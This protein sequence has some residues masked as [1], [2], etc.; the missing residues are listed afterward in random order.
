MIQ[1]GIRFDGFKREYSSYNPIIT[2][3]TV[4]YNCE[5]HIEKTIKSVISQTYQN[6]E[7]IIIDGN[8]TDG[9]LDI[10]RKYEKYIDYW[11]SEKDSGVFDAMNKGIYLSTS[12]WVL[13]LNAGDYLASSDSISNCIKY[14]DSESLILY[15]NTILYRTNNGNKYLKELNCDH[16]AKQL[17][18]QSCLYNKYLHLMYGPYVVSPRVTISDYLFFNLI[19]EKYWK[20]T[21][22]I[23]SSYLVD[24]N[25]S[26]GVSHFM[27]HL[28]VDLIFSSK[29]SVILLIRSI[30]SIIKFFIKKLILKIFK[31]SFYI[32]K[33]EKFKLDK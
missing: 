14:I 18:H 13:F 27:Q 25:I 11:I 24:S 23:I 17:I 16:Q 2:I 4:V 5:S 9:T 15:S 31:V 1:G 19:E 10:I 22:H 32:D 29:S 30:Y 3:I 33:I 12:D 8:S 28:G 26:S 21:D 7:Y 6:L 20:K